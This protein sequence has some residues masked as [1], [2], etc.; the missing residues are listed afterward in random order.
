MPMGP[1]KRLV[2][3]IVLASITWAGCGLQAWMMHRNRVLQQDIND[4]IRHLEDARRRVKEAVE[5][6][7]KVCPAKNNQSTSGGRT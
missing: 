4:Q 3:P 1:R 5:Q 2:L 6:L 7:E